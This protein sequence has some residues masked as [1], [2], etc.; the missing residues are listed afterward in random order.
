MA[1]GDGDCTKTHE[2]EEKEEERRKKKEGDLGVYAA[3]TEPPSL[4]FFCS[5]F[6]FIFFIFIFFI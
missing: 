5:I 4:I 6:F 3:E 2:E 1:A